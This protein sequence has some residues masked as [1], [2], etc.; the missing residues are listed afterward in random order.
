MRGY[1]V[2][3]P[4]RSPSPLSEPGELRQPVVIREA[5]EGDNETL[6][7]LTRSTPMAGS[8]SLRIDRDPD[9]F[10]LL[11]L[12]GEGKVYVAVRRREVIGCISAALRTTYVSGV[13]ET[14]A[15]VGDMKVHPRFSGTRI[16]LRLIQTL[17]AHLRSVGSDLCF[18]VVADGNRSVMPLFEGRLGMP[19]WASLGRFLVDELIPSPFLGRSRRQQCIESAEAADLPAIAMLL[20]RF[21]RSR[22]FA[23]QLSKDDLARALS[24]QREEPFSKM[25]VARYRGSIVATLSLHDTR[26]VK[27]NVLIDA[28]AS[29]R[30]ALALL[31]IAAAPLPG[32]SVPRIGEP[33]RVLYARFIACEEGHGQ[34]LQAL[35][36]MARA[37]AFRRR[38][39]FLVIGLH[40]RDPLRSL[41]RGI[42]RFTF[43]SLALATSLTRPE[44]LESFATGLPYEDFALV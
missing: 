34:A 19:R 21:H 32:F 5:V 23:P 36:A 6:L 13:P 3:I 10:A 12:R 40:E 27:R 4:D 44:R 16:A 28:S 38:F 2:G 20:D 24:S 29:L 41:L 9:F 33:L 17:E 26:D 42:P 31:R 11:R 35:V 30:C 8:I 1:D 43:S 18:S 25:L 15:Y 7:A 22:Q 37:E 14:V 39:T